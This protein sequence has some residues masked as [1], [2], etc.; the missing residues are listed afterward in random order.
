MCAVVFHTRQ[1]YF[2]M[3]QNPSIE[4]LLI[5]NQLCWAGYLR[6]MDEEKLLKYLFYRKLAP[7][8]KPMKQVCC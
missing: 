5:C 4:K 1:S 8:T 7:D 3:G 2:A 6:R